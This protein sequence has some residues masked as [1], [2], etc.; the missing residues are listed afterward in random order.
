MIMACDLV[1]VVEQ[2]ELVQRH[3]AATAPPP[4]TLE[5]GVAHDV[6]RHSRVNGRQCIVAEEQLSVGIQRPRD[7]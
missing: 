3:H 7:A 4:H 5:D 2:G 1:K 6:V